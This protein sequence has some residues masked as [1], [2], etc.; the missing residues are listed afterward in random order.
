VWW[1]SDDDTTE[2][3]LTAW[4]RSRACARLT[5]QKPGEYGA[6]RFGRRTTRSSPAPPMG[7][8]I[9]IAPLPF[10]RDHHLRCCSA[11][12]NRER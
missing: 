10:G 12:W 4:L 2:D 7:F 1:R 9:V 5:M 8:I 6:L 3:L 11:S